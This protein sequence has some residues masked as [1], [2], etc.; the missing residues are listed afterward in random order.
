MR[1]CLIIILLAQIRIA[2]SQEEIKFIEYSLLRGATSVIDNHLG[3]SK[4]DGGIK[5]FHFAYLR[6]TA[7][8]GL[9][10][11]F[12]MLT[13]DEISSDFTNAEAW[14]TNLS[15]SFY[16]FNKNLFG[17]EV[18]FGPMTGLRT[19]VRLQTI[20]STGASERDS[21]S[22]LAHLPLDIGFR[23]EKPILIRLDLLVRGNLPL[24][25]FGFRSPDDDF[26][27][28]QVDLM[29]AFNGFWGDL[30]ISLRYKLLNR[31]YFKFGASNYFVSNSKW[32]QDLKIAGTSMSIGVLYDFAK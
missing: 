21:Y 25:G 26:D 5:G 19:Y 17:G 14:M 2:Q 27:E 4:Y 15:L 24:V 13:A 18:L 11:R 30:D 8:N 12:V 6:P 22:Y 31:L 16:E 23:W 28:P 1:I 20:A 7:T 32:R 29:T 10:V 3:S 9:E